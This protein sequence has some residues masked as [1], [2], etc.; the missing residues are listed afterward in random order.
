MSG[1]QPMRCPECGED[2]VHQ[3][4]A[5]PV[6]WQ[7]HGLARPEWS[8]RDGTSLCPVIGP[9]GY[10][11]A[12]PQPAPPEPG[13]A[14]RRP[15]PAAGAGQA[16]GRDDPDRPARPGTAGRAYMARMIARLGDPRQPGRAE[17]EPEAGA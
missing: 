11:P 9:S 14:I 6:P 1:D 17:P 10:Q 5:D 2:A 16:S 4:P 8:H 13:A 3:P 15:Q 7:A 12:Q